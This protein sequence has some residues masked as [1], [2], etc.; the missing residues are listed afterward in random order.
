MQEKLL[1]HVGQVM[2]S[3]SSVIK[4][5]RTSQGNVVTIGKNKIE[6]VS[7]MSSDFSEKG[8]E[9]TAQKI[10]STHTIERAQKQAFEIIEQ[11]KNEAKVILSKVHTE[12]TNIM[13][14]LDTQKI[15]LQKKAQDEYE[16]II[17]E[18]YKQKE[19][20]LEAAYAEKEQLIKQIEPEMVELI[21]QLLHKIIHTKIISGKQWLHLFVQQAIEKEQ[22]IGDIKIYL[23]HENIMRHKEALVEGLQEL[24]INIQ[25]EPDGRLSQSECKIETSTGTIEYNIED[26][27]EQV[28]DEMKLLCEKR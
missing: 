24:P 19:I 11:A 5:Y 13:N 6:Q 23:S 16:R 14:E 28:V 7:S 12:K 26:G 17:Q 21:A 10:D 9:E 27:L 18:A 2:R 3:L 1:F 15:A 8:K 22:L 20:I 4:N 25:L